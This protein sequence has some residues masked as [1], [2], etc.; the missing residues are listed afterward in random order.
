[1]KNILFILIGLFLYS[2]EIMLFK[3][4]IVSLS[5]PIII[6]VSLFLIN[7]LLKYN[8][9]N[10]I[11]KEL[12]LTNFLLLVVY[13]YQEG[14]FYDLNV[15][16]E[17]KK[18]KILKEET[19]FKINNLEYLSYL[20]TKISSPL[21]NKVYEN[22]SKNNDPSILLFELEANK[23]SIIKSCNAKFKSLTNEF[24]NS[25]LIFIVFSFIFFIFL[26]ILK[27]VNEEIFSDKYLV[28]IL[29][30]PSI[31][32]LIYLFTFCFRGINYGK[33]KAS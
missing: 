12:L 24:E 8:N 20:T 16:E 5:F 25:I 33:Q 10:S 21:L 2:L 11:E 9:K 13:K 19:E 17:F 26:L 27:N 1:M 3:N 15:E 4:Y 22:I 7:E 29:N 31:L 28:L 32:Y 6:V 14:K 30:L 18:T 23:L